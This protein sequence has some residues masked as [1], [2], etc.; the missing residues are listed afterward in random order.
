[1]IEKQKCNEHK[2]Q[3]LAINNIENQNREKGSVLIL[4]IIAVLILSITVTGLLLVGRTELFT[5][6]SYLLEKS[7][8]YTAVWGVEEIRQEIMNN[9]ASEYLTTLSKTYPATNFIQDNV[10]RMYIIGDLAT[11]EA[12]I[13]AIDNGSVIPEE[14]LEK[15][16]GFNPPTLPG[17]ELGLGKTQ[18]YPVVWKV[19]VTARA[20]G[21]SRNAYAEIVCGV[22]STLS[23]SE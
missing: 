17:I 11:M 15:F 13:T 22:L 8:Y 3:H 6:Q 10:D 9:P 14:H 4:T 19:V 1:M 7:A 21:G 16:D 23:G 2:C 5:T 20:K 18:L 12:T